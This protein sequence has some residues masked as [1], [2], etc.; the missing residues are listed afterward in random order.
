[1]PQLANKLSR[2]IS[3]DHWLYCE[4]NQNETQKWVLG[5]TDFEKPAQDGDKGQ[6]SKYARFIPHETLLV[7]K[8]WKTEAQL[9][10]KQPELNLFQ[11]L[12]NLKENQQIYISTHGVYNKKSPLHSGLILCNNHELKKNTAIDLPL[13]ICTS[14]RLDDSELLILSACETATTSAQQNLFDPLSIASVFAASGVNTV[15]ATL[16]KISDIASL[17]F[18]NELLTLANEKPKT[19][20]HQLIA[21]TREI[22]RNKTPDDIA[23]FKKT[24]QKN[25]SLNDTIPKNA[26]LIEYYF[27]LDNPKLVEHW[28]NF[29]VIGD[30][31]RD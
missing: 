24:L 29:I 8:H 26:A 11:A 14:L 4:K 7:A 25:E 27:D 16:S 12:K 17:I 21:Q 23:A 19:P 18:I 10:D 20:W 31:E 13:W 22:F 3:I 6:I 15:I 2:E 28:A 5:V 1:M 9:I 30:V